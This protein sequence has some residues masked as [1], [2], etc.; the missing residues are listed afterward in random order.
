MH[1]FGITAGILGAV[2]YFL[3]A[4]LVNKHSGSGQPP[5]RLG[6][7][8]HDDAV[9]VDHTVEICAAKH[10]NFVARLVRQ[11]HVGLLPVVAVEVNRAAVHLS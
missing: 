3:L 1:R 11:R 8:L 5:L 9:A 7:Q 4:V 6:Q 2:N 10:Q